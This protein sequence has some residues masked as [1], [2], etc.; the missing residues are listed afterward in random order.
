M[1]FARESETHN[2]NVNI[3]I[4]PSHYHMQ[5]RCARFCCE[6]S[7]QHSEADLVAT[8]GVLLVVVNSI[9]SLGSP[10]CE[11]RA[12]TWADLRGG[13]LALGTIRFKTLTKN[14]AR[15]LLI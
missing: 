12:L 14:L 13:M 15:S 8:T 4:T 6:K 9:L 11:E 10:I 7:H 1:T 3:A 2:H 5:L